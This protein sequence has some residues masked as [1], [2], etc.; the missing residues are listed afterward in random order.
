VFSRCQQW[1]ISGDYFV[2]IIATVGGQIWRAV[3]TP[4]KQIPPE[5]R[6]PNFGKFH[7][8]FWSI[9]QPVRGTF[10]YQ[11]SGRCSIIDCA[12]LT[13]LCRHFADIFSLLLYPMNLVLFVNDW[14]KI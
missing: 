6:A 1:S 4:P 14:P 8:N 2:D 3:C 7:Q 9:R 10:S 13:K 12:L 5:T 11:H